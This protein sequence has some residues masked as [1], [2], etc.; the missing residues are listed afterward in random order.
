M[1]KIYY[2]SSE[3]AP[4][5]SVNSVS[6]FSKEFSTILNEYKDIDIRLTQPKYGYISDRRYILRE[7]IRFKDLSIEFLGKQ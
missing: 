2:L 1:L 3:I 4:F 7:V 6:T 5:S